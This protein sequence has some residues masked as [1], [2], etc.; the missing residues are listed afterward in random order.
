MSQTPNPASRRRFLTTLTATAAT[1]GLLANTAAGQDS[2]EVPRAAGDATPLLLDSPPVL[3]TPTSHSI[4]VAWAVGGNATGWVDYGD[5][6]ELGKRAIASAHGLNP[7]SERYLSARITGLTPGQTVYYR[8]GVAPI[9]FKNAYNIERGEAV[10]GPVYQFKTTSAGPESASFACINDTHQNKT[11]L[12]KLAD[13][14]AES[15]GDYLVWNGDVFNDIY[16]DNQVVEQILRPV[17]R[18]Y[19]AE[20]AVLFTGGNHDVRGPHARVLDNAV[21]PWTGQGPLG[22]SFAVRQGPLAMIGLDTGEDKPDAHPVF[23]G[24]A[25][26]EPYREA[27]RDWLAEVLKQEEIS[28]APHLVV[29][30]HIP[31]RGREG[32]NGGN[33]LEGYARYCQQGQELWAPLLSEAKAALVISGHTHRYRYDKPNDDFPFAQLVGGA[34]QPERAT[35]IRGTADGGTLTVTVVDLEGKELGSWKYPARRVV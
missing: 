2:A 30:C 29:F 4:G 27:Q 6:P 32:D 12:T 22:R 35:L 19:A 25:N 17:D 18:P 5:T 13:A 28:T 11:T 21:L 24:L 20:R 16:D 10:M 23:A 33:T 9:H 7:L 8:V 26:F 34:P 1:G 14:L 15:P 3:Q 31:L